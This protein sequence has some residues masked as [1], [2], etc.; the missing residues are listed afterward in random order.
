MYNII[1]E[2]YK[3]VIVPSIVG[4]AIAFEVIMGT[5]VAMNEMQSITEYRVLWPIDS[6]SYG[7][8]QTR[9]DGDGDGTLDTLVTVIPRAGIVKQ[10]LEDIGE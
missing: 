1:K 6:P 7:I 2:I 10:K 3:E 9:I 8:S 5:A 4:S